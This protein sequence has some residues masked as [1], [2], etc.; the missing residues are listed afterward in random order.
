L[1]GA[2]M[3]HRKNWWILVIV[4]FT[5]II[6]F[7]APY[8]TFDPDKS[9]VMITSESLQ[10]PLLVTHIIFA[11]I[12]LIAGF[13]QFVERIRLN[14]PKF[15]RCIGRV[16]V[17]SIFISGLLS[18]VVIYYIEDFTKAMAFLTLTILWL[19]TCWKGYRTAV[20]KRFK[21]HRIWMI[22]SFGITLVAVSGRILVPI[23]LLIYAAFNGFTL[24]GGREKMVEEVLNVNIWAG[25]V[26]NF[27]IVEWII[28]S[29]K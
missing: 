21:E 1:E 27:V 15:H 29:K 12:A 13:L 11:F 17:S 2:Q 25:L 8:L 3:K 24:P 22:R 20:K 28:L 14:K 7:I 4:S 6:P 23:L 18:F 5:I 19:F 26:L 9:R 10:Y 16:Y